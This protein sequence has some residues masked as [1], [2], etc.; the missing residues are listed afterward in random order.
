MNSDTRDRQRGNCWRTRV[1]ALRPARVGA[2]LLIISLGGCWNGDNDSIHLGDVSVGQ[3][4]IDLQ[5]AREAGAIDE[6][7]YQRLRSHFMALLLQA[8]PPETDAERE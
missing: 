6:A 5:R 3:Q 4:L 8:A 2:L 7:E 1:P